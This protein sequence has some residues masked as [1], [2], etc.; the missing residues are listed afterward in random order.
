MSTTE[1]DINMDAVEPNQYFKVLKDGVKITHHDDLQ[2]RLD[3]IAT[4]IIDAKAIGQQA[5]L[6][7]LVFTYDTLIKE[8]T[9]ASNYFFKFVYQDDVKFLLDKTKHIKIIELSRYPRPIPSDNLTMI[10]KAQDLNIFTD[11]CVVFT[12]MTGS[13]HTTEQEKEYVRRNRDPIVFGYFK[14][15]STGLK[16]DRFYLI[17]DWEDQYC[18]LT[19]DKL[20]NKMAEEGIHQPSHVITT[21]ATYLGEIVRATLDQMDNKKPSWN[22]EDAIVVVK[23]QPK[24]TFWERATSWLAKPQK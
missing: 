21:S 19:F 12:D 3:I 6:E 7:R 13:D 2:K 5:L 24:Q 18:D 9:L 17:T 16:H 14:H 11:Y 1:V 10:K 8:Q 22:V 20:I 23:D 15:K 4:H